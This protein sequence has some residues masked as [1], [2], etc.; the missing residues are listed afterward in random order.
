MNNL[1]NLIKVKASTNE[2]PDGGFA[3]EVIHEKKAKKETE[4]PWFPIVMII[5]GTAFYLGWMIF[6]PKRS[7]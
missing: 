7:R 6:R 5:L 1:N 2:T 4:V 3:A